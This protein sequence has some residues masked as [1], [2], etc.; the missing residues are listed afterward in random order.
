[1][2]GIEQAVLVAL[3]K[4]LASDEQ[5]SGLTP[6]DLLERTIERLVVRSDRLT[7]TLKPDL[8]PTPVEIPWSAPPAYVPPKIEGDTETASKPD[9]ALVQ[10]IARAH[11]WLDLL[12]AGMYESIEELA[13]AVGVHPKFVRNRIRLAF[14]SPAVTRACSAGL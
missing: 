8:S 12:T 10:A 2:T 4:L 7:P 9:E 6:R 5:F 3:R 11:I 13:V 1:A 14:L